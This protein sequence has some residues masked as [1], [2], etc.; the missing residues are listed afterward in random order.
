MVTQKARLGCGP[1]GLVICA[2]GSNHAV[3]CDFACI[4]ALRLD[5][6]ACALRAT[7]ENNSPSSVRQSYCTTSRPAIR[8]ET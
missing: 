1:A 5:L 7:H 3:V 6:A 4:H 8:H 2:M